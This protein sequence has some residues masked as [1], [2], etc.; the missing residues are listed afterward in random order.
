MRQFNRRQII[1]ST[2]S[3]SVGLL[4]SPRILAEEEPDEATM[5]DEWLSDA[6]SVKASDSPLK[7]QRFLEPMY[8]L[9]DPITWKPNSPQEV[10]PSVTA[11]RGFVTDLA[12]IPRIFWTA[13]RPDAD[14]AYAAIIHDYLYWSQDLPKN[15]AD[16]ILNLSM[17]DLE[18]SWP[19]RTAV[20]QAVQKFGGSAWD[21]NKRLK[22]NGEKRVLRT[23]PSSAKVRWSDWKKDDVF[24]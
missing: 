24:L 4:I 2:L 23:F 8:I 11:P 12:S 20:F 15:D 10:Y 6:M 21:S 17:K 13:L 14:Y 22:A 19:T 3:L 9:L 1:G 18:V 7:L 5:I 16:E